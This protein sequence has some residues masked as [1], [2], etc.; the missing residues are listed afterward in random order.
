M[1]RRTFCTW[2]G[3]SCLANI[4]SKVVEQV[5]ATPPTP[6]TSQVSKFMNQPQYYYVAPIDKDNESESQPRGTE[7]CPFTTIEQATQAIAR[8]KTQ[9]GGKL[10]QPVKVLLRGGNYYL[11]RPLVFSPKDSGTVDTPITYQSYP[12]E[13]AIISG[14]QPITDWQ[15]EQVN[16]RT[17]WTA[18]LPEVKA[19][20]WYFQ[21]LWVNGSRRRRSRYPNRGYLKVKS[22]PK[23]PKWN[24]GVDRFDYYQDDLPAGIDWSGGEAVVLHRWVE[25]RLEITQVDESTGTI[26]FDNKSLFQLN[27]DDLFYIN[28]VLAA[29]DTPGE[30]HLH[31][32]S[33]KLYYLPL[34]G[35]TLATAEIIAPRLE[36]VI[37]LEGDTQQDHPVKHLNFRHLTFSHTDWQKS[38]VQGYRQNA[39]GIPGAV[40]ANGI[41]DCTWETCTFAHLGNHALE[42]WRGC[43]YNR[44][45]NCQMYDLGAGGI[46]VGRRYITMKKISPVDVSHHNQFIGNHIF[47]GGKFFPSSFG[48]RAIQSH[49]NLIAQN[50]IHDFYYTG[51]AV[52]GFWGFQPTP[53]YE[54]TIEYNY[55]HHIGKLS[56]GEEPI[57]SDLG[58]IYTLGIQPGTIIRG[59]KVHDIGAV[60]YGGRGIYL[61]EGS[62]YILVEN[63]LVYHTSH[64]LFALH[65]GQ[66]NIVRN[67]I[68]AY[69]K[70]LVI[71]RALRDYQTAKNRKYTNSLRF[72]CNIF[73]WDRDTTQLIGGV[74]QEPNYNVVFDYNLYWAGEETDITFASLSWQ[75]WR[76]KK[77]DRN[78]LIADPLFVAPEQGNFRL[79]PNSPAMRLGF[80]PSAIPFIFY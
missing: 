45:I 40:I 21:Q 46:K 58:G 60:H 13:E 42:L 39:L 48:L 15:V 55:V 77:E 36:H 41:E 63:N 76:D 78:S 67:N 30:W 31:Q 23:T 27:P 66:E 22:A 33:G 65:Y 75:Q 64:N 11:E 35:E 8:L 26:N 28:N 10:Q 24:Q 69:G 3:L 34:P 25:S 2:V 52:V 59:N 5:A 17:I 53:A 18:W 74:E 4:S 49:D 61:D 1:D 71:Y 43:R 50:Q 51:I 72:E 56:N 32:T 38:E 54:N 20:Q 47:D 19:K 14:G 73:C 68:F 44:V 37:V 9:Q 79:Q 80:K 57:L 62:S 12:G 29:L 7:N 16:G 6:F 70:E